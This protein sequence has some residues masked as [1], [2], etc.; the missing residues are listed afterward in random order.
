MSCFI[1]EEESFNN[2]YSFFMDLDPLSDELLKVMIVRLADL[3]VQAF[4]ERYSEN[5]KLLKLDFEYNRNHGYNEW[6]VLKLCASINY[7]I[8]SGTDEQWELSLKITEE[9]KKVIARF[10]KDVDIVND[11]YKNTWQYDESNVW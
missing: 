1:H 3:E 8:A 4:N 7:Q 5:E 9:F 11:N 10:Y 6:D 2:L